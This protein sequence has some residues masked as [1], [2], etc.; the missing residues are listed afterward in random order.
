MKPQEE[1]LSP[2]D[3][4]LFQ[5]YT[6]YQLCQLKKSTTLWKNNKE[7]DAMLDILAN[8]EKVDGSKS[9]VHTDKLHIIHT[10]MTN[11]RYFTLA[12]KSNI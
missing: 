12:C 11:I 7:K 6:R 4:E 2:I 1:P 9:I 8:F 3:N 10:F 5:F